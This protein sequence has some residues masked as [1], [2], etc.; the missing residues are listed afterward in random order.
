MLQATVQ[1]YKNAYSG[2]S[3]SVWWLSLVV[4]VNRFGTMVIP[5]LTVYLTDIGFRELLDLA[6]SSE[7]TSEVD[8]RIDTGISIS[9]YSVY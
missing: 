4:F 2:L 5:F 9:R 8:L 6:Q 7:V 1:L 3:N